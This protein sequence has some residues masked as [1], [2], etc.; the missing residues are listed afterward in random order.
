MEKNT[1]NK[2][3]NAWNS[4]NITTKIKKN[5]EKEKREIENQKIK[6]SNS[7]KKDNFNIIN[8]KK[9]IDNR[10]KIQIAKS[11]YQEDIDYINN[12]PLSDIEDEEEKYN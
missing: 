11:T 7:V 6:S 1:N 9:N 4:G 5:L 10:F 12:A 8:M 2:I 3:K